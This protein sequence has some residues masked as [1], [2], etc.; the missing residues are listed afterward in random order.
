M[1]EPQ[2]FPD[3]YAKRKENQ[4]AIDEARKK[5]YEPAFN[6]AYEGAKGKTDEEL[7]ARYKEL[8]FIVNVPYTKSTPSKRE[9]M[10]AMGESD[11]IFSALRDRINEKVKPA[12]KAAYKAAY[13]ASEGSSIAELGRRLGEMN[14]REESYLI[15]QYNY[16]IENIEVSKEHYNPAEKY[17]YHLA[18]DWNRKLSD[19]SYCSHYESL[20]DLVQTET[21]IGEY[22]AILARLLERQDEAVKDMT[23]P[24]LKLRLDVLKDKDGDFSSSAAEKLKNATERHAISMRLYVIYEAESKEEAKQKGNEVGVINKA[25]KQ[26]MPEF[27][28]SEDSATAHKI[29]KYLV[30]YNFRSD[31]GSLS[32]GGYG[33][34]KLLEK[35]GRSNARQVS[36]LLLKHKLVTQK[37]IDA[38]PV[39][40]FDRPEE[41]LTEAILKSREGVN[42]LLG[43][44]NVALPDEIKLRVLNKDQDDAPDDDET[45]KTGWSRFAKKTPGSSG[46]GF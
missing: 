29:E 26:S 28:I 38:L 27:G 1:V 25:V 6:A 16:N 7:Y 8:R 31:E 45:Q 33:A 40:I 39:E 21:R 34:R 46:H 9:R 24:Q 3:P 35:V 17:N 37:E 43:D 32:L 2:K 18:R 10:P 41:K 42:T 44:R 22:Q 30:S 11:G 13:E 23:K 19:D 4:K 15:K 5:E 36:Q 12:Y 20:L 14:T